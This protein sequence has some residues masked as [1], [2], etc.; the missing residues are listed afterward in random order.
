MPALVLPLV[1]D[2]LH[3]AHAESVIGPT[4]DPSILPRRGDDRD[5]YSSTPNLAAAIQ[6]EP[7]T[8]STH[9]LA[10]GVHLHWSLP[11]ALTR[12]STRRGPSYDV[13]VDGLHMPAAP[14]RWLIV[15]TDGKFV[16]RVESDYVHPPEAGRPRDATLYPAAGD[17]TRHRFIG[18]QLT[19][20][21]DEISQPEAAEPLDDDGEPILPI[22]LDPPLTALGPGDPMF[23]ALYGNCRSVFGA[24][25]DLRDFDGPG[26]PAYDVF[27]WY[28]DPTTPPPPTGDSDAVSV[29]DLGEGRPQSIDPLGQLVGALDIP[30]IVSAYND[31]ETLHPVYRRTADGTWTEE[32]EQASFVFT[33]EFSSVD[34]AVL[35]SESRGVRLILDYA[36]GTVRF[37]NETF[38][39]ADRDP[40][41]I[42]RIRSVWPDS[43]RAVE[44]RF[45]CRLDGYVSDVD[46]PDRLV[47]HGRVDASSPAHPVSATFEARVAVGSTATEALAAWLADRF[48]RIDSSGAAGLQSLRAFVG[49]ERDLEDFVEG[50]GFDELWD[51]H[52]LDAR[53]AVRTMRHEQ[54]FRETER[55]TVWKIRRRRDATADERTTD[56]DAL[57]LAIHHLL[58][59]LNEEM[60]D[61][62]RKRFEIASHRERTF[63]DWHALM[64]ATYPELVGGRAVVDLDDL[65]DL[66]ADSLVPLQDRS[67][68]RID[69]EVS[70]IPATLLAPVRRLHSALRRYRDLEL[71]RSPGPRFW[72]PRDPVVLL[73]HDDGAAMASDRFGGS[74]DQAATIVG[75]SI[76]TPLRERR[77]P[78][79]D[80]ITGR[81][82]VLR[83]T[84]AR[85]W[86][87][88]FLEWSVELRPL[89]AGSNH[90][91]AGGRYAPD[92][93]AAHYGPEDDGPDL[94][95]TDDH[96]LYGGFRQLT[97]RTMLSSHGPSLVQ[98]RIDAL[99]E[100]LV[101]HQDGAMASIAAL[102]A[103]D[104]RVA[105]LVAMRDA[106]DQ[107][108][109][110]SQSLGGFHDGLLMRASIR[111]LPIDD[112]LGF[113]REKDLADEVSRRVGGRPLRSPLHD[114]PFH[115]IR[116]GEMILSRLRL[117]DT[118]G[119]AREWR[120]S[121]VVG[122]EGYRVDAGGRRVRMAPRFAQ[123]ARL[124]LRWLSSTEPMRD[125]DDSPVTTPILGWLVPNDL[126][127]VVQ[128][129]DADGTLLGSIDDGW[130][131]PTPGSRAPV[132]DPEH[133]AEPALRRVV[134]WIVGAPHAAATTRA[135]LASFDQA[136]EAIEP[137]DR[138]H[139]SAHVDLVGR[140]IALVR[141]Q[142]SLEL[143]GLPAYDL[144][145]EAI[146]ARTHGHPRDDHG[147]TAVRVPIRIGD[148][149]R[150]ND[151]VVG[152]WIERDGA[153][154]DRYLSPHT[155]GSVDRIP[156]GTPRS[157][158]TSDHPQHPDHTVWQ[159][160]ADPPTELT[161]LLDPRGALHAACGM[162]PTKAITVPMQQVATALRRIDSVFRIMPLLT[163]FDSIAIPSPVETDHTWTWLQ[164]HGEAWA[165]IGASLDPSQPSG[166]TP[167]STS[168]RF[169]IPN[170]V[171]DGYLHRRAKDGPT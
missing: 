148:E 88:L 57:P 138:S 143:L 122:A 131:E 99:L 37:W 61:L 48:A 72:R 142:L 69:H 126:D 98:R 157:T 62:E 134:Q 21:G 147:F 12:G 26:T 77:T 52:H 100:K 161:V 166:M 154:A 40:Y 146:R 73:G 89:G 95:L 164:H 55:T 152:Y 106:L 137:S 38:E 117:V 79:D 53:A 108:P 101:A 159:S 2:A 31:I 94:E 91:G 15:R 22:R 24:H 92:F 84:D 105:G 135:M 4:S 167:T 25:D 93:I 81:T 133:I 74:D 14:N 41:V 96:D 110:L 60:L 65:G 66:V 151:G 67:V 3:L 115:P 114:H 51:Q 80:A 10:A 18:R 58:A 19:W 132:L 170:V 82:Q 140:P 83:T 50:L 54:R 32:H 111:Q 35:W 7:F 71:V 160:V 29:I 39:D 116:S 112:P 70:G 33:E 139:L 16:A 118:F 123:P 141:A 150:R 144:S 68:A 8:E 49:E 128:V 59:S 34:R 162:V 13:E 165:E 104:E 103:A 107:V 155:D 36:A 56:I 78:P 44:E 64:E 45:A 124:N 20:R 23:A 145:W 11:A 109:S 130:W 85:P 30:S 113:R 90:D 5:H 136:L 6:V 102:A 120:P 63:D 43:R 119:Q 76:F 125:A 127:D 17:E 87:P 47:C 1:V 169:G 9:R 168:P 121:D 28:E 86:H 75:G 163:P 27:G 158:L 153:L 129:H 97:G 46:L 171:R 42:Y 149:G 156:G